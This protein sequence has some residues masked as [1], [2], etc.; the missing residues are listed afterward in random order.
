MKG[1]IN[2]MERQATAQEKISADHISD[3]GL[4][5]RRYKEHLNLNSEETNEPIKIGNRSEETLDQR[6]TDAT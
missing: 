4:V 1:A 6:A 5:S 2:I 3:E